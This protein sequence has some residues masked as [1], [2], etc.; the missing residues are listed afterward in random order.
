MRFDPKDKIDNDA[1][2][3]E[4][5]G[6]IMALILAFVSVFAFFLKVLFF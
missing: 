1:P 6:K 4:R 5:F 2:V 3:A